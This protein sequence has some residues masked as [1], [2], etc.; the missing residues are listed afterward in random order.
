MSVAD[1]KRNF[2]SARHCV[3]SYRLYLFESNLP[4][5][6]FSGAMKQSTAETEKQIEYGDKC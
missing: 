4:S 1:I 5:L 3:L 6:V 2:F